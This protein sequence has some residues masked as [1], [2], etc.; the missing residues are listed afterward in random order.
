MKRQTIYIPDYDWTIHVY[1]GTTPRD[2][3]RLL[4][5]LRELGCSTNGILK[6]KEQLLSGSY[7]NGFTYSNRVLK[8]SVMSLGRASSFAQFLNSFAHELH[9]LVTHIA[10]TIGIPLN[11]E[12]ICYLAGSLAQEMYDILIHYISKCGL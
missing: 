4:E 12:E 11:G 8:E 1:Y 2:T 6:T 10:G 7:N 9:H 3:G 5:K